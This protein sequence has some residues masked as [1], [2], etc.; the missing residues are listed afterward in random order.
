MKRILLHAAVISV[1]AVS[2]VLIGYGAGKY[3]AVTQQEI[4]TDERET[5]VYLRRVE[6]HRHEHTRDVVRWKWREVV[7]PD[8]TTEKETV[9]ERDTDTKKTE[10]RKESEAR[11]DERAVHVERHPVQSRYLLG[12]FGGLSSD[13]R[14]GAGPV[15]G[16]RLVGPLWGQAAADVKN[17]VGMLSLSVSF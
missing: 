11:R 9:A 10:E 15:L 2:L 7:R 6:S 5:V 16:L 13:G 14:W 12:V 17:R 3:Q 8:G 4:V 1:A